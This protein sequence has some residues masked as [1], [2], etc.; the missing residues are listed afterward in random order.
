MYHANSIGFHLLYDALIHFGGDAFPLMVGVNRVQSQLSSPFLAI[1]EIGI[2]SDDD[3]F[4]LCDEDIALVFPLA[5]GVQ[6]LAMRLSP[7]RINK[8]ENSFAENFTERLVDWSKGQQSDVASAPKSASRNLLTRTCRVSQTDGSLRS[9]RSCARFR[10]L[11]AV[12]R[13]V[14]LHLLKIGRCERTPPRIELIARDSK[15]TS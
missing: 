14:T 9:V 2:K 7:I 3:T 6:I 1:D 5:G 4:N 12:V 13:I 11:D 8:V 10:G 15:R